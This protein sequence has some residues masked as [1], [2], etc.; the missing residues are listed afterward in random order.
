MDR[1]CLQFPSQASESCVDVSLE[2]RVPDSDYSSLLHSIPEHTAALIYSHSDE[3]GRVVHERYRIHQEQPFLARQVAE[4]AGGRAPYLWRH[5]PVQSMSF[6][7]FSWR[8]ESPLC[9]GFHDFL[10]VTAD[11]ETYHL[12]LFEQEEHAFHLNYG[13]PLK[14]I[15]Y[16]YRLTDSMVESV[17]SEE[18]FQSQLFEA[19]FAAMDAG[20]A[21]Q[22]SSRESSVSDQR[23]SRPALAGARLQEDLRQIYESLHIPALERIPLLYDPRG[24]ALL[25]SYAYYHEEGA[26]I[27]LG[28]ELP[29]FDL[30]SRRNILA[31]EFGHHH[32]HQEVHQTMTEVLYQE[33][34]R[35]FL[36]GPDP[37]R[38]RDAF[39]AWLGRHFVVRGQESL[40]AESEIYADI[41]GL[42]DA[43]RRNGGSSRASARTDL[44]EHL[45]RHLDRIQNEIQPTLSLL[46]LLDSISFFTSDPLLSPETK[47]LVCSLFQARLSPERVDALR[48]LN[49]RF[50]SRPAIEAAGAEVSSCMD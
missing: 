26:Y 50:S 38:D 25:E 9:Q 35:A 33:S 1:I 17:R 32:Y 21:A 18:E 15:Q 20:L 46:A 41:I 47:S 4:M 43:Y 44:V 49:R 12:P 37:I 22:D 2:V 24:N 45:N 42:E 3:S 28:A 19:R 16:L 34:L 27:A 6:N 36:D 13:G 7:S 48:A 14:G 30:E 8:R 23:V 31:H 39:A 11:G 40:S 10:W 29:N 5:L